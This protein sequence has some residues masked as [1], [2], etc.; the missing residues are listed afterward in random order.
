MRGQRSR[1]PSVR[2]SPAA[3]VSGVGNV[4]SGTRGG[5]STERTIS[6]TYLSHES[7]SGVTLRWRD[8]RIPRMRR[9]CVLLLALGVLSAVVPHAQQAARPPYRTL[10]DRF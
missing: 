1:P 7:P 4:A 2:R 6:G 9:F 8:A 5:D 3:S 10:D